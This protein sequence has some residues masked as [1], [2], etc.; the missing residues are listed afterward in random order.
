MAD[1]LAL[2]AAATEDEA[3]ATGSAFL[4]AALEALT[5]TLLAALLGRLLDAAL[6]TVFGAVISTGGS[7]SST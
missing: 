6:A 7:I 4:E 2:E 1:G 3:G 5:V